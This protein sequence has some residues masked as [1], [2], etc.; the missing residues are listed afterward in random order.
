VLLLVRSIE[1]ALYGASATD[2]ISI[3]T[4]LLVLGLAT[5]LA[6]LFPVLRATRIDPITLLRE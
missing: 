3:G 2:P 6:C 1:S 5:I 4:S